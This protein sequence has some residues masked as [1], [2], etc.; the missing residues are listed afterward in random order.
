V[1]SPAGGPGILY[2][3]D[4]FPVLSQTFVSNEIRELRRL[5]H[6][7]AVVTARPPL[8][9]WD[10]DTD[11]D[12]DGTPARGLLR[13]HLTA[14]RRAPRRYLSY[15]RVLAGSAPG[16]VPFLLWAPLAAR[17]GS[18]HQHV[19]TH[20]A[21]RAAAFARGVTALLGC[22]RSVTTHANDLFVHE[23]SLRGRLAGARVL[24]IS[25]FNRRFLADRGI[26]SQ[27]NHCGVDPAG[28]RRTA[29]GSPLAQD[30]STRADVLFVGRMVAKKGPLAFVEAVHGLQAATGTSYRAAMVGEGPLLADCRALADRLGCRIELTGSLPAEETVARLARAR[31]LCLPA[32]RDEAGDQDGIP[33]VLME[34]MAL[35]TPVVTTSVSG[36]P[37]LVQ[38]DAGWLVDAGAEDVPHLVTAA[39]AEC[40]GDPALAE[41]RAAR[42]REVVDRGFTLR[43]QALNVAAVAAPAAPAARGDGVGAAADPSRRR[44]Q[45]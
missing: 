45:A 24:T 42:A 20:F 35:G 38:P 4:R 37:E 16:D 17:A 40:L 27:V 26:D 7:V 19:H 12:A 36:I 41:G 34:A 2:V 33:V 44:G 28:L 5:G 18:G 32:T 21:F 13:A 29:D 15:L 6:R 31:V 9:L 3:L 1:T 8:R 22:S 39:L 30:P 25:Q 14:L 23:G 10:A 43:Q 11:L